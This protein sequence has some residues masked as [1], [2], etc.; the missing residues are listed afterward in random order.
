MAY[1]WINPV[2][3]SMYETNVLNDF[4]HQYGFERIYTSV[5]WLSV[6]REKYRKAV[7]VSKGTVIDVRCPKAAELV[8]EIEMTSEVVFP[9]ISPILIH[10]GLEIA[11]RENLQGKEIFITTPCQAL[12][13]MGNALMVKNMRFIPWNRLLEKIGSAPSGSLPDQSPIPLGFFKELEVTCVSL[14]GE[15]TIRKYFEKNISKEV[16]LVE[17][18]YCKEGCHNGDGI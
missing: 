10:C 1:L 5:D 3:E 11:E 18:L 8:K 17:M 12:A 13:D 6:V 14:S 7:K 9:E 2:T 4:I 16:Q 15:E